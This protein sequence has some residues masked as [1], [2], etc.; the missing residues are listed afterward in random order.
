MVFSQVPSSLSG[1]LPLLLLTRLL[2][3]EAEAP[4]WRFNWV[5]RITP[6]QSGVS[7]SRTWPIQMRI[8]CYRKFLSLECFQVLSCWLDLQ[9]YL[10]CRYCWV[11][12]SFLCSG[13]CLA[14][15]GGAADRK[16][17]PM[18][19]WLLGLLECVLSHENQ[20]A[21]WVISSAPGFV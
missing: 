14:F 15:D 19:T 9:L 1:S 7:G 5:K 12:S 21:K 6:S 18:M 3:G 17:S 4:R 8:D 16:S 11:R 2:A 13:C 10:D 20:P